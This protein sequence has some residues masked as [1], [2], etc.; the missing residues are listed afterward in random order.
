MVRGKMYWSRS[1]Y[2]MLGYQAHDTMLS[3]G[4]VAEIIHHDDG[5]LFELAKRIVAREIDQI[6][7]V[8]RM[9]HANGQWVWVRARAQ[10][11]DPEGAR[12]SS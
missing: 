5:D 6:D 2:D 9:R 12:K 7:Q 3:F 10:V 11:I 8:F 4:E 1:M